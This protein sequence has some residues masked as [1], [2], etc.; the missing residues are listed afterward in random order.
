MWTLEI[1]SILPSHWDFSYELHEDP[2]FVRIILLKKLLISSKLFITCKGV[3]HF[4]PLRLDNSIQFLNTSPIRI[5]LGLVFVNLCSKIFENLLSLSFKKNPDLHIFWVATCFFLC[6]VNLANE[7]H[8]QVSPLLHD[9]QTRTEL[10]TNFLQKSDKLVF[11]PLVLLPP[12]WT[13]VKR[14][15]CRWSRR[16]VPCQTSTRV[17]RRWIA[18]GGNF[19]LSVSSGNRQRCWAHN[20]WEGWFRPRARL[21]S[22]RSASGIL[23]RWR[24][25]G[26]R[27]SAQSS[28]R[29]RIGETHEKE[30]SEEQRVKER[31]TAQRG[32]PCRRDDAHQHILEPCSVMCNN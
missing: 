25:H 22:W 3:I 17:L 32:W 2:D 24:P 27:G 21:L 28:G 20:L 23:H 16:R 4:S 1:A 19:Q 12:Q 30:K 10:A 7:V 6:C 8:A 9:R 31:T 11:G 13:V 18:P 14:A 29:R 15:L 26:G 5:G